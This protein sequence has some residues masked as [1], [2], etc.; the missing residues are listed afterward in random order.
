MASV[1][2]EGERWDAGGYTNNFFQALEQGAGDVDNAIRQISAL[3]YSS[4]DIY[5]VL[6]F[7]ARAELLMG[8]NN[9]GDQGLFPSGCVKSRLC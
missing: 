6:V 9:D 2:L 5:N 8:A 4:A 1:E 7:T 3:D